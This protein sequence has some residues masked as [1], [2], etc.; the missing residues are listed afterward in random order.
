[1]AAQQ[2]LD[3]HYEGSDASKLLRSL[4]RVF[5]Y[6]ARMLAGK[7]TLRHLQDMLRDVFIQEAE[8]KLRRERPGKNV[9]LSQLALLTGLDTRTLIRIRAELAAQQVSGQSSLSISE[10]SPEARVIEAWALN[11]QYC[12]PDGKPRALNFGMPGSEFE[13][14]VK[15]VITARGVTVQSLLAR[16][17]ATG[18]VAVEEDGEQLRLL[19]TRFS[20]FNSSDEESLMANGLQALINLS[21]TVC[22]NVSGRAGERMIQRELWTYRLDESR[23]EEFRQLVKDFLIDM[24][25]EAEAVMTPLESEFRYQDQITAGI[26]F[27]YF[28]EDPAG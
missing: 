28:E 17:K 25:S 27:Y 11:P 3:T 23:R 26:G 12:G 22:S 20:P 14:L 13:Q 5:R 19:T 2:S 10:L 21:G 18:S 7:V 24:E 4:E 9:P 1:M 16:L 15:Q 6:F 8:A